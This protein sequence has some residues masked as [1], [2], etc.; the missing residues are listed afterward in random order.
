MGQSFD[1]A[2]SGVCLIL[3]AYLRAGVAVRQVYPSMVESASSNSSKVDNERMTDRHLWTLQ[4][5][6][7]MDIS[8]A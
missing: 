4:S 6:P 2:S 3:I 1:L 8:R 5:P 7:L